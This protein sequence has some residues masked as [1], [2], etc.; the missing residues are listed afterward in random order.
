MATTMIGVPTL[1]LNGKKR[2]LPRSYHKLMKL[3]SQ[4][5][6]NG[7]SVQMECRKVSVPVT[8]VTKHGYSY[9]DN[10]RTIIEVADVTLD[11]AA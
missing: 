3:I 2:V 1:V 9:R 11:G 7:G 5:I 10:E 8:K 4:H 6:A